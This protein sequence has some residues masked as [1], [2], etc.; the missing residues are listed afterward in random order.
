MASLLLS[1]SPPITSICSPYSPVH[2]TPRAGTALTSAAALVTLGCAS[3]PLPCWPLAGPPAHFHSSSLSPPPQTSHSPCL[4]HIGGPSWRT[5]VYSALC[6]P[7]GRDLRIWDPAGTCEVLRTGS[8]RSRR[9][10]L[11]LGQQCRGK[12]GGPT[13]VH[14][15]CIEVGL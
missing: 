4:R 12:A 9:G 14:L 7:W 5:R 11:K 10:W 15:P 8:P 13:L 2:H 6:W 1:V 3:A